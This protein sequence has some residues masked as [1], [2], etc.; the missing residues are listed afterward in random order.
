MITKS[1]LLTYTGI[2]TRNKFDSSENHIN[3]QFSDDNSKVI[4][5]IYFTQWGWDEL[6]KRYVLLFMTGNDL[7][8]QVN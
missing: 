8:K 5:E 6:T 7:G 4:R 1:T 3:A 2:S